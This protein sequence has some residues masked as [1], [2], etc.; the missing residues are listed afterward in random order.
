MCVPGFAVQH[1]HCFI[2]PPDHDVPS[3]RASKYWI[4][5]S[6]FSTMLPR[7]EMPL[8]MESANLAERHAIQG[9]LIRLAEVDRHPRHGAENHEI[10]NA[11]HIGHK[12]RRPIL[13]DHRLDAAALPFRAAD[14]RNAAAAAGNGHGAA[15]CD[16][17]DQGNVD[18]VLGM[19]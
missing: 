8:G 7:Q 6:I 17:L 15:L 18:D 5:A 4:A 13:V 10:G 11:E 3:L 16:G 14:Y 9:L 1:G 12:R 19:W 2:Q